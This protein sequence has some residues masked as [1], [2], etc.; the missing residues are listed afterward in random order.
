MKKRHFKRWFITGFFLL[1]CFFFMLPLHAAGTKTADILFTHDLHSYLNGLTISEDGA[2]TELGGAA[3]LQTLIKSKRAQNPN[4]LVVDGGDFSMGTLFQTL[5]TSEAVEYRMLAKLGF[6][7]TTFGNHEFDYGTTGITSMLNTAADK[8]TNLP[9]LVVCNIDWNVD[10]TAT[11]DIH[12]AAQ[13]TGIKDYIIVQKGD[14]KI[15]ITGI[16]GK[17]ALD[18]APTCELT[19]LD[20][21]ESVKKTVETMKEKD[22]PDLIVCISHNGVWEGNTK[23]EGDEEIAKA[24]PDLDVIVSGH[25]HST[26]EE[27]LV[28]GNTYI[29]SCGPYG[30]NTGFI[31]L[32]QNADGSW[33]DT[34]Y[35]L[36]RM[37]STIAK[38]AEVQSILDGFSQEVDESYLKQFGYTAGQTLANN[39]VDFET[40][41]LLESEHT[42]HKLGD[43][44]ADAYRY[45]VDENAA[46]TTP[47]DVSVVPSGVV[48]GT[49]LPGVVTVSDVFESFS[50]GSGKDGSTGYPLVRVYLTG[51]ELKTAA[52]VDAS[53]SDFMTTARLYTSGLSFTYNPNRMLLNKVTDIKINPSLRDDSAEPVEDNKVYSVVTDIYSARM[54]DSV[55]SLSY[56]ILKIVPKDANGNA[57]TNYED[58]IIYDKN[59]KEIKAWKAIASYFE[60]FPKDAQ[61]ISTVPDYYASL[62]SRKVVDDSHS[63]TSLFSNPSTIAIWLYVIL[64]VVILLIVLLIWLL[65]RR[66]KKRKNGIGKF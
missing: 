48:R 21:I 4:T 45:A 17:D 57:I 32:E 24:V 58:A 63:L 25:T 39:K 36:I 53:V 33:K 31:S 56:G 26:L 10:N 7:A 51:K 54:L 50:L 59:G 9:S 6:D 47:V 30:M 14:V 19:V 65:V 44:M 41:D 55:N 12:A 5:Y 20:P 64:A 2:L 8:E 23:K 29:V 15:G 40:I 18:C 60:S 13:R 52:E 37:D 38:D 3:R 62:H 66:K 35:E 61:G 11:K 46:D 49:Y 28:V 16:F 1:I 43:I 22:N 27:P 34:K 42:E